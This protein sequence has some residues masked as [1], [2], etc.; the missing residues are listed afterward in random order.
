MNTD[1]EKEKPRKM[2]KK[3][4]KIETTNKRERLD[5]NGCSADFEI[6]ATDAYKNLHL[7]S[8]FICGSPLNTENS[9]GRTAE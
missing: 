8:V 1:N 5:D 4:G 3:E 6:R 9:G 2:R 7:L